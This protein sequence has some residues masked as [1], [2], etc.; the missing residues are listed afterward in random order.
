MSLIRG[1][2]HGMARHH[3][4]ARRFGLSGSTSVWL[5]ISLKMVGS[6]LQSGTQLTLQL[7]PANGSDH[8]VHVVQ[9]RSAN[10]CVRYDYMSWYPIGRPIGT[11]TYPG[12][13]QL[14]GNWHRAELEP[15]T[16][17]ILARALKLRFASIWIWNAA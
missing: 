5:S 4:L 7:C 12:M 13:Q 6:S 16:E 2:L 9:A 3:H 1:R 14:G 10:H 11:T 15:K 17:R 8:V